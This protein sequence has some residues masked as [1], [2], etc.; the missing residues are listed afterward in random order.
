VKYK[1][2]IRAERLLDGPTTGLDVLAIVTRTLLDAVVR[3]LTTRHLG[4]RRL[5]AL[6]DRPRL[7]PQILTVA[8]GRPSR[9]SR[10][11]WSLLWPRIER[12]HLGDG[13]ERVELHV[14][15]SAR[16]RDEQLGYWDTENA[17]AARELAQLCDTLANRIGP[18]RVARVRLAESHIPERAWMMESE[19]Q[20]QEHGRDAHATDEAGGDRPTLLIHPP[21]LIRTIAG[22]GEAPPWRITWR[23]RDATIITSIGPERICEVWWD[24]DTPALRAGSGSALHIPSGAARDYFKV[25]DEIG[26]WLWVFRQTGTSRWFLH[27]LWA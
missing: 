6:F 9:D 7:E 22:A 21:E 20:R 24:L 10:H 1:E 27:G 25:Q 16:L 14:V 2:P 12:M 19:A 17:D 8:I 5:D 3:E 13:V 4:V 26:R 23:D 18:D 11:L 15:R